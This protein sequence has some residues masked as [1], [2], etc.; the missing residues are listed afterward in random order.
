MPAATRCCNTRGHTADPV[1]NSAR[2]DTTRD[3]TLVLAPERRPASFTCRSARLV[4]SVV[5]IAIVVIDG[6][7]GDGVPI[8][9]AGK[10][11]GVGGVAVSDWSLSTWTLSRACI[12]YIDPNESEARPIWGDRCGKRILTGWIHTTDIHPA[13]LLRS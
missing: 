10:V 6:R 9:E 5:A 13:R 4:G 1:P 12:S 2:T 11:G 8:G 7:E 3:M